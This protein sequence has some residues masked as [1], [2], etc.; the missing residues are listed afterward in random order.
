MT[1]E[2]MLRMFADGLVLKHEYSSRLILRF[3]SYD[4][5]LAVM[6]TGIY[7]DG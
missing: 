7:M 2:G 5:G 1:F 6:I 4:C 3:C